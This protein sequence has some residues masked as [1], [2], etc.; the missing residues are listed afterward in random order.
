MYAE[1]FINSLS[2]KTSHLSES[3]ALPLRL[4]YIIEL[5][6]AQS[7][8]D[9]EFNRFSFLYS[10]IIFRS[11]LGSYLSSSHPAAWLLDRQRLIILDQD[12]C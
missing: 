6:H 10:P 3:T 7:L 2:P 12:H 11:A 4:P 5:F 1:P 8:L 9:L